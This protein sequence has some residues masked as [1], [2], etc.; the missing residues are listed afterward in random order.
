MAKSWIMASRIFSRL[1]VLIKPPAL[2]LLAS[3]DP[4]KVFSKTISQPCGGEG[5]KSRPPCGVKWAD[6][7]K[8]AE[9]ESIDK[10][11]FG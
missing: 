5:V 1:P 8:Q 7:I 6:A 3:R 10:S 11:V 2:F 9:I 4:L